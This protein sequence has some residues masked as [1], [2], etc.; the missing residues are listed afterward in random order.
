MIR[1]TTLCLSAAAAAF[2]AGP[3]T[4]DTFETK[5]CVNMGNALDAPSEGEW[6]HVIDLASFAKIKAAGFDTVRIPVRWSAH[7]GPAPHFTIN[8]QFGRRV[9]GVINAAKA[10]GLNVIVNIHHF[11]ELNT[12]PDA[13]AAKLLSLWSQIAARYADYPSNVYFE[14]IN[15]PNENFGGQKMRTLM[16][17]A[18]KEIRKTNPTRIVILG[19]EKWNGLE[20]LPSI[21]V[22]DDP[23]QVYTFH[24][25]TPFEFTHQKAGWT[26]LKD[27]G[28]VN[29]G[30]RAD[31]KA[32]DKN[33][34][35][36]AKIMRETGKPIF[37]GEFGAYDKAPY[38]DTVEYY[39][40][41]RKAFEK[42]GLSWCAWSFTQTFPLYDSE[43]GQWDGPKLAALGLA[44]NK[45]GFAIMPGAKPMTTG[46][47]RFEG[48]SLDDGFNALRRNLPKDGQLMNR[49]YAKEIAFYGQ[50]K[51]EMVT[52]TGVPGSTAM[53]VKTVKSKNAWDS[54]ASTAIAMPI[55]AGDVIVLSFY[56]KNIQGDGRIAQAGLQLNS[57]P[58]TAIMAEPVSLSDEWQQYYIA[59]TAP[60]DYK[61][62]EAGYSLHLSGATQTLRLGPLFIMNLG[63]DADMSRI[64]RNP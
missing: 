8:P 33:M 6:G 25:Y 43:S 4:A 9:D 35:Y 38:K 41:T 37:V 11:E 54:G 32:L 24:Y 53:E 58:Y 63:L 48:Q 3:A 20:S 56:G 13:H 36:A 60:R 50:A 59:G 61:A 2:L 46:G 51:T 39:E 18:V 15:E 52:D 40:A 57:E 1:L 16:T 31:Y 34:D 42:H 10:A 30:S 22:I 55:K 64:P 44:P 49:P 7:T 45:A 21:P 19:G 5:R 17:A 29:F 47:S 12:D 14:V 28:T 26:D 62:G 27:S 23:N